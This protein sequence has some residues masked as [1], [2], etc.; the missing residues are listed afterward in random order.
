M[1][2][3]IILSEV[4]VA[5][6]VARAIIRK[7]GKN[8]APVRSDDSAHERKAPELTGYAKLY[9][10]AES[11]N[12]KSQYELARYL[13]AYDDN[14]Y[15]MWLEKAADNG[16]GKAQYF[17]ALTLLPEADSEKREKIEKCIRLL[18]AASESGIPEASVKLGSFYER[19][20]FVDKDERKALE[21][22]EK[23]K[24]TPDGA[25][26]LGNYY[27]KDHETVPRDFKKAFECFSRAAE[28]GSIEAY[29]SLGMMYC[30]GDGVP[31]DNFK[32][33]KAFKVAADHHYAN[34]DVV[35]WALQAGNS[36]RFP[37]DG[38]ME[39]GPGNGEDDP[40]SLRWI[41]DKYK[42]EFSQSG[43]SGQSDQ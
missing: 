16:Y 19:G 28:L 13:K 26:A 42:K 23:G 21:L 6:M 3:F 2:V 40:G 39:I 14:D 11:G 31:K 27:K 15:L 41:L 8:D 29:Y 12:P 37:E 7:K 5:F 1:I 25:C 24:S 9:R 4:F 38:G 17:L 20:V 10:D 22:Y 34:S 43:Q 30:N 18:S 33:M 32:A 35:L 36:V